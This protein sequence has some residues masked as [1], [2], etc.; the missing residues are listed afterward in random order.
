[1]PMPRPRLP[2]HRM[3]VA[4]KVIVAVAPALPLCSAEPPLH[5]SF[6]S[7]RVHAPES[8]TAASDSSTRMPAP[9]TGG[10][11]ERTGPDEDVEASESIE[12]RRGANGSKRRH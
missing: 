7:L 4:L 11:E 6:A 5:P 3:A 10:A 9:G 2:I 8:V 1:M 12:K